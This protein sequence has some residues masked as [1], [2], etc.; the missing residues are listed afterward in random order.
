MAASG[1]RQTMLDMTGTLT[2]PGGNFEVT[3]HDGEFPTLSF[4]DSEASLFE[5][6]FNDLIAD[7]DS[8]LLTQMF[9]QRQEAVA[10]AATFAKQEIDGKVFGG[11]NAGDNEIG[12]DVLRPGQ[13]RAEPGTGDPIN[14]WYYEPSS[15]GWN[16]WI[17]DDSGNAYN[18]GED[19]VTVV[20]G[21]IDQD[22][23]TEISGLDVQQFGRNMDML[24]HDLNDARLMDNETEQ[25]ATNL[26]TLIAQDNDSIH[27]Q[28]RHDRVQE[29]QPRLVGVTFGLGAF[30]NT[31]DYAP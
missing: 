19:Q 4:T 31:Q 15:S 5:T 30:L 17:G 29:S 3:V 13:I 10:K 24:P 28:L 18:V 21:F 14:D 1:A 16:D 23:S 12:F 8:S 27:I 26:P 25:M 11:I 2:N 22:V 6:Q 20:L 7:F 9:S